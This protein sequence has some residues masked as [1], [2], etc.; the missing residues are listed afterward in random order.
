MEFSNRVWVKKFK[1]VLLFSGSGALLTMTLLVVFG[2]FTPMVILAALFLV[3]VLLIAFL[4]FQYVQIKEEQNKLVVRY[5]S[6][7]AFERDFETFEFSLNQLRS[8]G[9]KTYFQGLKWDVTFT[10]R[11]QRGLADFPPVSLSAVPFGERAKLIMAL[12][13]LC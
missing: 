7:F 3:V 11:V 12:R 10:I 4:N 6:V 1:M 2:L 13:K 9:I 5:Y 8:V